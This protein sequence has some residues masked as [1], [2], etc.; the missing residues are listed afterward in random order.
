M[1]SPDAAAAPRLH[2]WTDRTV[3]GVAIASFCAGFGQF[4]VVAALG[5]VARTFGHVV[6][7]ATLA[8][9]AGLSGTKLG[10]GLAIIRLASLGALAATGLADRTGRRRALISSVA[11]GLALTVLAAASPGYW[12]FVVIFACGRPLLQRDR[13]GRPGDRGRTDR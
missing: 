7:G 3:I 9:Q 6:H 8:D 2:R 12:W 13:S 5:S 10:I 1:S 4:G 11:A